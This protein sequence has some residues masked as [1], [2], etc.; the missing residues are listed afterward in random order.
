MCACIYTH[1]CLFFKLDDGD[2][3]KAIDIIKTE[4]ERTLRQT[5]HFYRTIEKDPSGGHSFVTSNQHYYANDVMRWSGL[6]H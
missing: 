2:K 6:T 1:Y 5:R 4:L 3:P